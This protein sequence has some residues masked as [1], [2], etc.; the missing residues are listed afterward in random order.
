MLKLKKS[1]SVLLCLLML[2]SSFVCPGVYAFAYEDGLTFNLASLGDNVSIHTDLQSEYLEDNYFNVAD[3]ADGTKELSRPLPVTLTWVTDTGSTGLNADEIEYEIK[4]SEFEDLSSAR[5]LTSTGTSCE[6]YNLKIGTDYYWNVT[7]SDNENNSYTSAVATFTTE[8]IGPRNLYVDGITNVRD[9]GGYLTVDGKYTKQG[10]IYRCGRLNANDSPDAM[11][12]EE[13]IDEML[14]VLGIKSEIDLRETDCNG[15][16]EK[17]VLGESVNYYFVPMGYGNNLIDDTDDEPNPERIKRFFEILSDENNY[18]L[19]FHCSIGTDRTGLC[20][21]LIEGLLGVSE[22]DLFRDYLFSNFGNIGGSRKA[23][24]IRKKYAYII[25]A[26]EGDTLSEKTYK[27][28]NEV[29]GVPTEKLDKVIEINTVSAPEKKNVKDVSTA[30]EFLKMEKYGNYRLVSDITLTSTYENTFCGSLDGNGHTVTT[31][32]PLFNTLD[33]EV[34]NLTI[35]GKIISDNDYMGALAV[36]GKNAYVNNVTNEVQISGSENSGG[37]FGK[38]T[39]KCKILNCSNKA[40]IYSSES[41]GGFV[42]VNSHELTA[43][44]CKNTGTI[45]SGAK[46][47]SNAGVGGIVG[48]ST[49]A[50]YAQK[51]SN[52]A[53]INTDCKN[54]GPMS[55]K[56]N[57]DGVVNAFISC[58]D[59]GK[60]VE[61][62][63]C[64]HICHQS[65]ILGFFWKIAQFFI[66]IFNP[67][68]KCQC[69]APHC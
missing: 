14:N 1:L 49:G 31:D 5:T 63:N 26:Y 29:I 9:T 51:C 36:Y 64:S 13:G 15:G 54:S 20:A 56:L 32:K 30:E 57:L 65:G 6:V 21:Y 8:S 38:V 41:A 50:V 61:V 3:Y 10:M 7:A 58:T 59:S 44:N 16:I 53:V 43:A 18:P 67:D 11:I 12:T 46:L 17:S 35:S 19:I 55:G 24:T 27:Y 66:K 40:N 34:S 25:K 37:F 33:G 52:I 62:I 45:N 60:E 69:G 23:N 47:L 68:S 48:L 2:A 42:A 28:L 39:G 4:I 22:T